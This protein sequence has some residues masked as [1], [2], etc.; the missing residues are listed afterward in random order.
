[1]NVCKLIASVHGQ[2]F[3][4]RAF[5]HCC[6]WPGTERPRP[7][8]SPTSAAPGRPW[9]LKSWRG[10]KCSEAACAAAR[11]IPPTPFFSRC[12]Q[13][14]K[15]GRH[16]G[17][18]VRLSGRHRHWEWD[19]DSEPF[20]YTF[21]IFIDLTVCAPLLFHLPLCDASSFWW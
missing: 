14:K 4:R 15:G 20:Y 3:I 9:R 1:M 11:V 19:C 18:L 7:A 8:N 10:V 12:P 13:K 6:L 21:I 5:Q 16:L 17:Q 2:Q